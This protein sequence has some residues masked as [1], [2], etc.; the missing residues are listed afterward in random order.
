MSYLL[1]IL[2]ELISEMQIGQ[3]R[4]ASSLL[5][6][7][8]VRVLDMQARFNLNS[9]VESG[10]KHF[11]DSNLE[12]DYRLLSD[13]DLNFLI[14]LTLRYPMTIRYDQEVL[15]SCLALVEL[16]DRMLRQ[17]TDPRLEN[18]LVQRATQ[19]REQQQGTHVP[20]VAIFGASF[21][22]VTLGHTDLIRVLLQQ[23]PYDFATIC[24]IPSGQ[25]PLKSA[26]EY[27]SVKDRS[28]MLNLAMMGEIDSQFRSKFRIDALELLRNAPSKMIMSLSLLTL[29]HQAQEAYILVC[30]YDHLLLMQAWYRWQEL[31]GLCE[32]WFYPRTGID[33]MSEATFVACKLLCEAGIMM[34]IV[35][36][37]EAQRT[38]WRIKWC[39]RNVDTQVCP[40]LVC[41]PNA[42]IRATSATDLRHFYQSQDVDLSVIPE[43]ISPAV[44]RYIVTHHLF[45]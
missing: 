26:L 17:S 35:F 34:T 10:F 4:V 9:V 33:I 31:G 27:A 41:N 40:T 1:H 21:N 12:F 43:G 38:A 19:L 2:H 14:D 32:L 5:K 44:H 8:Y 6:R 18:A 23:I 15:P 3:T 7:D 36:V 30:G 37:E 16:S 25:S 22:P 45:K 20:R 13:T 24:L 39:A 42:I 29:M 28:Q 11:Q